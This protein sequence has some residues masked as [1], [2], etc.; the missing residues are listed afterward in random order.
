MASEIIKSLKVGFRRRW[1]AGFAKALSV[2]G[3]IWLVTSIAAKVSPT[4]DGAVVQNGHWYGAVVVVACLVRFV[5]H[6]YEVRSVSFSVPTTDSMISVRFGDLLA[7]RTDWMVG[8]GEFFDSEVGHVV[9]KDSLHGKVIESVFNGDAQRFRKA[10]DAALANFVGAYTQRAFEPKLKYEIGTTAVV[11]N[12]PH[13]IYLV[14]MS[15]VDLQ[16]AKA[17][18]TVPMLWDALRGA[19]TSVTHF[20][21][22]APLSLPLIGNGRSSV[23]IEPQHLLRLIVL[24]LVDFGRKNS[25]PKIVNVIVPEGCFEMLDIREI[26]RDWKRR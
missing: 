15:H 2:A 1:T 23:N 25:L 16:T 4:F 14:A 24:A 3:A 10:V 20:G 11:E 18:S 21:N 22:G 8:V 5:V 19:L 12:G 9:S 17:S 26:Q 13:K 7:E 6:I